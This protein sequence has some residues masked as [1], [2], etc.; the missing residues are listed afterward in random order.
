MNQG[1]HILMITPFFSPNIGGVETHLDDLTHYLAD[2][3]FAVDVITYKPLTARRVSAP[4]LEHRGNIKIFRLPWVR[5]NLFY[6]LESKPLLQFLYLF[7]GI[8]FLSFFY[9]LIYY[10]KISTIHGHGL[11]ASAATLLLSNIFRKKGIVSLHTIYKFSERPVLGAIVKKILFP[12]DNILVLAKGC[13]DDLIAIGIPGEKIAVYTCWVDNTNT[14]YERNKIECRQKL[15][16][17]PDKFI[18][19]FVGRLSPEKGVAVV[20]DVVKQAVNNNGIMFVL[21]GDGPMRSEVDSV[22]SRYNNLIAAG[23]VANNDLKF[24]YNAA[25]ILLFGSADQDYYGR[26][27][28]EALSSGLPVILPNSAA[29]FGQETMV[30]IDFP[31]GEIGYMIHPQ[32]DSVIL[33]LERQCKDSHGIKR[34]AEKSRTYALEHFSEKNAEIFLRVLMGDI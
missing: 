7:P 19:L 20:L 27:T 13:K 29:Y 25:D 33:L 31:Q 22:A 30:R 21:V 10:K 24:Y 9:L 6:K 11:A 14:F 17:P 4:F 16:L 5:F 34:M 15:G 3:G 28:M 1:R 26:V 8:F 2:E 23:S 18:V 32:A 12:L